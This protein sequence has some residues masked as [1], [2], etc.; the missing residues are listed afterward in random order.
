MG[1]CES[2]MADAEQR[3]DVT[4]AAGDRAD[5]LSEEYV[6]I[7]RVKVHGQRCTADAGSAARRYRVPMLVDLPGP[8]A[9]TA[10]SPGIKAEIDGAPGTPR[11]A[12]SSTLA[13]V[14]L[15]PARSSPAVS[16]FCAVPPFQDQARCRA[17][18]ATDTY[19]R[20]QVLHVRTRRRSVKSNITM[21]ANDASSDGV[22]QV[23]RK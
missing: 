17:P 5:L 11:G 4:C 15:L 9:E 8:R 23:I 2:R 7:P 14:S 12:A 3:R 6:C 18:W 21:R 1:L 13:T 20:P 22:R 19:T 10:G 16:R